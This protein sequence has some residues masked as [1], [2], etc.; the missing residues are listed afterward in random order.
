VAELIRTGPSARVKGL[1]Y[2][3]SG[4]ITTVPDGMVDALLATGEWTPVPQEEPER[5]TEVP[6][7]T[8]AAAPRRPRTRR[9]K[10]D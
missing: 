8:P 2:A 1:G 3:R 10:A 7:A 9:K 5:L 6:A 4:A